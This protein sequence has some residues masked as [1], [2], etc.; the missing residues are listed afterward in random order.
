MPLQ[1]NLDHW[2]RRQIVTQNGDSVI[3]RLGDSRVVTVLIPAMNKND[4]R[5]LM[6]P[7]QQVLI[8][9]PELNSFTSLAVNTPLPD[10]KIQHLPFELKPHLIRA[11]QTSPLAQV[12]CA[13][14]IICELWENQPETALRLDTPEGILMPRVIS[15]LAQQLT[16]LTDI[17]DL[18]HDDFIRHAQHQGWTSA[19]DGERYE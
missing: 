17:N 6:T 3:L 12:S 8:N 1:D 5:L 15:W 4:W 14:N 11:W 2:R 18:T 9:T 16:L 13:E 10:P 19:A 7:V